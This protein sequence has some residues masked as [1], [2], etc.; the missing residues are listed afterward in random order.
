MGMTSA[1]D[2]TATL[3]RTK[4]RAQ[5]PRR[6]E[7]AQARRHRHWLRALV[8]ARV[9]AAVVAIPL[10][11]FLLHEHYFVLALLR[12]TPT[13]LIVGGYL[14]G[15]GK[16]GLWQIAAAAAPMQ[17]LAVWLYYAIGRAWSKEITRDDTL[18]LFVA[19]LLPSSQIKQLRKAVRAKAAV[20]VFLSRFAWVPVG[21]VAASAGSAKVEPRRF[22]ATDALAA[23]LMTSLCIGAGYGLGIAEDNAG[24]WVAVVGAIGLVS[25][26]SVVTLYVRRIK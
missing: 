15:Q 12:P 14:A 5:R 21:L 20:I 18:P 26:A 9:T 24:P 13:V 7:N 8:V 4:R 11:P 19:R 6:G 1:V 16:T 3:K 10:F 23:T 22:M 25:L 2:A 17:L